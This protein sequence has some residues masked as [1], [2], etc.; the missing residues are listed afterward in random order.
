[1]F[2]YIIITVLIIYI[3]YKNK[4]FNTIIKELTEQNGNIEA[5]L[6]KT[7]FEYNKKDQQ[8]FEYKRKLAIKSRLSLFDSITKNEK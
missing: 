6:I 7:L 1:M 5:T 8:I 3:F 4:K 2:R